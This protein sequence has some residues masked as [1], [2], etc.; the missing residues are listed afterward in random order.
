MHELSLAHRIL[1][2]VKLE[3]V[4]NGLRRVSEVVVSHGSG[5]GYD[6]DRI[7]EAIALMQTD[8]LISEVEIIFVPGEGPD[9]IVERISG[10]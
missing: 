7:R 5:S 3:A 10:E 1:E 2:A 4:N 9:F 8:P 6:P